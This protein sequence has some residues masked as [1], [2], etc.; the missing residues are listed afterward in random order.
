MEG[1]PIELIRERVRSVVMVQLDDGLGSGFYVDAN[2][3]LVTSAHVV[4]ARP[5]VTIRRFDRSTATAQVVRVASGYD[6]ALLWDRSATVPAP[7]PLADPTTAASGMI[8]YAIGHPA[9][10]DFTVTRGIVSSPDRVVS[11]VH[12]V[13]T[14]AAAHPG[15]SGGPLLDE[16]GDVLGVSTFGLRV[17][18]LSFALSVRYVRELLGEVVLPA[19]PPARACPACGA[20]NRASRRACRKC[21]AA[22]PG[23]AEAPD[24]ATMLA[25]LDPPATLAPDGDAI[26]W[27]GETFAIR[28][29]AGELRMS[30]PLGEIG[31]A[32]IVLRPPF[33]PARLAAALD[34]LALAAAKLR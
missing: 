33:G 28:T 12:Y 29:V 9:G 24:L 8:A 16:R 5:Q 34:V 1:D 23:D 22:L 19:A 2:G 32:S 21:G 18:G 6:L 15:S 25:S 26:A 31:A 7:I 4:G 11:D 30:R 17:D 10:L 3:L 13:Q 27:R 20:K 14:D